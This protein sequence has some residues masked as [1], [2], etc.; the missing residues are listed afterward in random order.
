[1]RKRG[2]RFASLVILL[3][4]M[5]AVAADTEDYTVDRYDLTFETRADSADIWVTMDMTY[6]IRS[7]T[8]S[9]GFK[10]IGEYRAEDLLGRDG[11]GKVIRAWTTKERETKLNWSFPPAGPGKKR[12]ILTFRIPDALVNSGDTNDFEANWAGIFRI[13]VREAIYRFVFPDDEERTVV[14]APGQ[15]TT[16]TRSGKRTLE[17]SQQ[18]LKDTRFSVTFWPRIVD[19]KAERP[20]TS[21]GGS[22]GGSM[23]GFGIMA[24]VLIVIGLIARAAKRAT[25]S[26]SGASSCAGGS[27]CSSC[28]SSCGGGCGGGGCGG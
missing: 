4:G 2:I 7:G 14:T 13:A 9:T 15:F 23:L 22:G 27:S 10:Y 26:W 28:G 25:G 3:V 21:S 19:S 16:T 1:M 17:I 11:D 24:A 12:I 8:K 5:P 18:P 20:S 6:L